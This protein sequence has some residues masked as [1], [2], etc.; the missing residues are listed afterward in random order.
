[1]SRERVLEIAAGEVGYREQPGNRTKYGA[2]Y[3]LDG[4]S[5]CVMFLWW[6]FREAG[7][8]A[9][10]YGGGRTAS[11]GALLRWYRERGRSPAACRPGDIVLLNFSGSQD[12]AHCGL[13]TA[14]R[15]D[16]GMETIEGNTGDGSQQEGD[17][18]ARKLRYPGQIV[19]VC[20]PDYE[21]DWAGHWAEDYIRRGLE[22]GLLHGYPDGSFCPDKPITRGEASKL[23]VLA[24]ETAMAECRRELAAL[25]ETEGRKE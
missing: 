23:A 14:V 16:G 19:G 3:G 11:C 12:P 7:E 15:P 6:C 18:V 20:R 21:P 1:M 9:A 17:C 25:R 5:W 24:C 10:F 4:Y 13:V 2:A 8:S 22:L